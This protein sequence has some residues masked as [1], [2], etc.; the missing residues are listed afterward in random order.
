MEKSTILKRRK[1]QVEAT[2]ALDDAPPPKRPTAI[3]SKQLTTKAN[4]YDFFNNMEPCVCDPGTSGI[5]LV[6]VELSFPENVGSLIRLAGNIGCDKVIFTG[7]GSSF[8]RKKISSSATSNAFKNVQW[9]FCKETEWPSRIP[10]DFEKVA[11]ETVSSAKSIYQAT[12]PEKVAFVVGNESFGVTEWSLQQCSQSVFI[13]MPGRIKSL[14]VT[15]AATVC[16]FEWYRRQ[17]LA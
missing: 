17:L 5:I 7:D 10:A 8:R 16:A 2:G 1:Q 4:S 12:L 6:A 9:E 14:N 15:Q 11:I 13:P 3:M